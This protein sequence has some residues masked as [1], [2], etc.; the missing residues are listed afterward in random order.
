IGANVIDLALILPICAAL[1]GGSLPVNAQTY[2]LDLPV[3]LIFTVIAMVPTI[4]T[5]K[6]RRWQG[7]TLL[8]GYAVYLAMMVSTL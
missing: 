6:F 2:L 8:G 5:G 7:F 3:C 4:I 1:S